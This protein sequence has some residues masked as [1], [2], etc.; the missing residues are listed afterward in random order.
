[1]QSDLIFY[2]LKNFKNIKENKFGMVLLWN[3]GVIFGKY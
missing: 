2:F 3:T 1:M